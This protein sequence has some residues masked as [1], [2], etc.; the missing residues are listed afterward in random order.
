MT[1]LRPI[2]AVQVVVNVI[3]KLPLRI[4]RIGGRLV[5]Q[6][7]PRTLTTGDITQPAHLFAFVQR[8]DAKGQ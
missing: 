1:A 8:A 6:L 4:C 3:Q 5:D 2:S 7:S